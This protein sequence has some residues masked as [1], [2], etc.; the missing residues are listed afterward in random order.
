VSTVGALARVKAWR[1]VLAMGGV[2]TTGL[3]W[4]HSLI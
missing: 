3:L 2:E 4:R 1:V